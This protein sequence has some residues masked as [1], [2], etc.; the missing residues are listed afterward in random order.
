MKKKLLIALAV[1][2]MLAGVGLLL[3]PTLSDY[4]NSL[5]Y[6]RTIDEYHRTVE[7]LS[8]GERDEMLAEAS[9][10]NARLRARS[11]YPLTLKGEEVD[12]YLQMLAVDETGVMGYVDIPSLDIHLPIYHGTGEMVLQSGVGHL[13]G[14]S[15]PVGGE[16]THTVLAG[17]TGL[18]STELFTHINELQEGDR[19]SLRVLDRTLIYEV[20]RLTTLEATDPKLKE[21]LKIEEGQDLCT[22]QTCTPYGINTHRLFV[23]GH[24]VGGE[25]SSEG[26][27]T[28]EVSFTR[29]HFVDRRLLLPT[30][31]A[32]VAIVTAIIVVIVVHHH[33]KKK[34]RAAAPAPDPPPGEQSG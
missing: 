7:V 16:S 14:S 13:Q 23:R 33:R 10:Y 17:H 3:Y 28:T 19:F 9:E 32:A 30:I 6:R 31:L 20:D 25:E 24:R 34:A 21:P 18:P 15:L 27:V 29:T 4:I 2:A 8:T 12:E 22:L 26:D 1:V 5:G 11:L